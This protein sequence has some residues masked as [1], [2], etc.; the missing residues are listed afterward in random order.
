MTKKGLIKTIFISL[1]ITNISII[2]LF[3]LNKFFLL[4]ITDLSYDNFNYTSVN[5]VD[6]PTSGSF[7]FQHKKGDVTV[8][9]V[10]SAGLHSSNNY[11]TRKAAN[12][13]NSEFLNYQIYENNT[14]STP[15]NDSI[16][17]DGTF[18]DFVY[19]SGLLANNN[20]TTYTIPF[21]IAIPS[22][23]NVSAGSYTDTIN[24]K[25]VA[26]FDEVAGVA[27]VDTYSTWTGATTPISITITV[28]GYAEI[29]VAPTISAGFIA[30]DNG[31]GTISDLNVAKVTEISTDSGYSVTL[32]S[33]N[34]GKLIGVSTS[35]EL[36]YTATYNNVGVTLSTTPQTISNN[37]PI[38]SISG[39]IKDFD[40]SY[41][42]IDG[43]LGE[44]T[45]TDTLTFTISGT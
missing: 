39:L 25:L 14:S 9:A 42:I 8:A 26:D 20:T 44:D 22:G 4:S 34:A 15:W 6:P 30:L 29:I 1:L 19:V 2:P 35:A 24:L 10:F 41:T 23:Q 5:G 45:Y 12:A 36:I 28:A 17:S 11:Q 18:S 38:T 21:H 37:L 32:I 27:F 13:G 43:V 40:I 31:I 16:N 33:T 3:A 7:S